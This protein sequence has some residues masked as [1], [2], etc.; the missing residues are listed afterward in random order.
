MTAAGDGGGVVA[1]GCCPVRSDGP[2]AAVAELKGASKI[3]RSG[4]TEI[5]AL[6]P[7]DLVLRRNELLLILGPSGSGKTTLLSL[8]GCVLYP[9]QGCVCVQGVNTRD[10][11]DG[12]MA[13][14]RL[15][16][17]GFV[18]QQFNLIAPLTAAENVSAPLLLRGLPA[19][20]IRR[21]VDHALALVGMEARRRSLP[22]QLSGGE[23][24]RIAIARALVTEPAIVLCD[25]PTAALDA[26]SIEVVMEE[27]RGL[28]DAG[29]AVAV[30]THDPRLQ[31][32]ADRTVRLENGRVVSDQKEA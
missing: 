27:L 29:K 22:R 4:G 12:A 18:F 8:L 11:D 2:L 25:E 7:T 23:Q 5:V 6:Q 16:E 24:Q 3:F 1:A 30:V 19:P 28:A 17:I 20:E 32:L 9:S 21:R 13:R 26:R 10:L 31:R 14:L 15:T